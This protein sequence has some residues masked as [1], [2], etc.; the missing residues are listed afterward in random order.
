M[1]IILS[2]IASN[3]TTTVSI[4]GL[5]LTINGTTI[6]LSIIP[7]G[8]EA[9]PEENAPFLGIITREQVTIKYHYDCAKAEDDQSIDWADYTFD[10]ESGEVPCPIIWKSEEIQEENE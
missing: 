5:V 7:E 4:D 2:P 8:G 1:K 9:E 10:I 6:D 3:H